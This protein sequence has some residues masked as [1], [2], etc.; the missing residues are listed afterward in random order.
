MLIGYARVSTHDQK[1]ALQR[2]ALHDARC[3]KIFKEKLSAARGPLTPPVQAAALRRR[4]SAIPG[5][6]RTAA[7]GTRP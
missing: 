5:H 4:E 6:L 7:E 2:D 1:L 3:E